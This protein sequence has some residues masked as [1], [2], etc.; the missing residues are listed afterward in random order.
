M[1][2]F[3]MPTVSFVEDY[4]PTTKLG[5]TAEDNPFNEVVAAL[6]RYDIGNA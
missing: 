1:T 5:R 3:V 4:V 6:K 2:K